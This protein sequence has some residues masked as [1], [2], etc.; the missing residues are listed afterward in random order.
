MS[1]WLDRL[2][3]RTQEDEGQAN[4]SLEEIIEEEETEDLIDASAV[5]LLLDALSAER[6]KIL[7]DAIKI[8]T[9]NNREKIEYSDMVE[10]LKMN[11]FSVLLDTNRT[12]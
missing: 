9:Q 3:G 11:G 4:V 1:S 8:A 2:L 10:A 7:T 5:K 6:E 12:D